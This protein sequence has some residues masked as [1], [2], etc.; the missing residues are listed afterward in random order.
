[1]AGGFPGG[2]SEYVRVPFGEVN[3]LKCPKELSGEFSKNRES[4][5]KI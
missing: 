5:S 2:Q 1:M 4:R 3:L